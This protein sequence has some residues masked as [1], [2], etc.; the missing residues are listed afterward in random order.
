M[1]EHIKSPA[2][3]MEDLSSPSTAILLVDDNPANLL[4]LRAIFDG[5][6]LKIMEA[7]SGEEALRRLQAEEFAVILLDV[8]MPGLDGFETARQIR[9]GDRCG[10]TPII[11]V[12]AT[13]VDRNQLEAGYSLGAVD[14]L[15]KPVLPVV[16]QA[17]VRGFARLYEANF[18]ARHE[19]DQLRLLIQGT[20]EYAIFMLDPLG[21]IVTWNPGAERLKGYTAAEIIG[22]HFSRFYPQ[23]AIG[24]GWPEYELKAAAEQGRFED[25]GWRIRKDG[26]QFWANVNITAL[27]DE[28][29]ELR[30]FSKITR[31]MTDR[32]RSEESARNLAAEAAARQAAEEN[33][34]VIQEQRERLR[35]TLASIGDAVISTDATGRVTFLN[36]VAERL[37]GWSTDEAAGRDLQEIFQ[38]VNEETRQP[39]ANPALRALREGKII[40]LA[41]HTVL[42]ARNGVEHPIDDSA[43]P[44]RDDQG[45]TIG[46]VLVFRDISERQLNERA[47]Q[48]QVSITETLY[49]I[50]TLLAEER[51]LHRMVQV[52]TDEGTQLSGAQ[53]GAFFYNLQNELGESY[54]L[55]TIS[56][57]PRAEFEKFPMP[58]NTALFGPT[59]EGEGIVCLADVTQD[60]RYG[61]SAPYFGMPAGHLPVRSYL[62][63]PVISR[64]GDVIGGLF[65]GH[66]EVGVFNERHERLLAG[67]AGQAAVA[68]DNARLNLRAQSEAERF[69]LA[70]TAAHLG[71]WSWDIT[72]DVVNMSP[73]A[74]AVFGIPPGPR[75]TWTKMQSLL[76]PDDRE[77]IR[78]EVERIIDQKS[79]YDVEYRVV[80]RDG[81]TVWV[82]VLGRGVYNEAGEV[83]TMYG[84][85]RDI[86][87]LHQTRQE[88][89]SSEERLRLALEAGRMGVWDWN[90]V[91][92]DL[93]WS[94]SLE[95]LYG[96]A[97]G[98]F[99]GTAEDFQ[100]LIHPD[101]RPMVNAAIRRAI[102]ERSGFDL[103]FRNVWPNGDVHWVAGKA[104][105]FT[106]ENGR[107]SRMIGIGIDVTRRKRSE[108][109][110]QFLADASAALSVLVDFDSTLQKV[111]S[112]AVPSFADWASVVV[113]EPDNQLRRVAVA[114]VDPKK[115]DLAHKT[116]RDH[117]PDPTA[118]T[119]VWNIIRTG[120]AE[121]FS[122]VSEEL[123]T[124]SVKNK[125]VL[126]VLRTLGLRSY[127]GVPLR[128]RGK[129][130]GVIT[131]MTAESG[132]RY[133]DTDLAV[134]QDLAN[135]TAIAI[136]NSQLYKEL[137]DA[138]RRKDEFLATLAHELRNPLAPIRNGLE[139]L[140][141]TGS[142][143]Q[144]VIDARSM[145]ERQLSQL[146]RLVDDLLDVSRITRNKLELRKE[147]VDLATIIHS[148][149]ETSRPLIEQ[150]GHTFSLTLPPAPILID[151]DS[152]RLAQVFS[153]LLNNS[154]K[155]TNP[156]GRI[157]LSSELHGDNVT[158]RVKDSGLGIPE[159]ALSTIFEMF[160]QVARHS[161]RAQG[162]LGIGL[163]LVRRI[164]EM[165][166]GNVVARSEGPGLGSEFIVKLPVRR[167]QQAIPELT[168]SHLEPRPSHLKRKILIVDDNRDAAISLSMMLQLMGNETAIAEDGLA[169][170]DMA[171]TFRPEMILL[172]I[173]LPRLN[174][175]DACRRIRTL[176]GAEKIVIVALTGWG[177]DADRQRSHEAG[178]D[179]HLVKPVEISALQKL[180]ASQ[181]PK[182]SEVRS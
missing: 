90:I 99:G 106:G 47:L 152:V 62:A 131:F 123:L 66:A 177:Q 97:P 2:A 46:S 178:F 61:K 117:P 104:K 110:A 149:I 22:Q 58:R 39:V 122:E 100:Q 164:V 109:T 162:G 80:R 57:V 171:A 13:D 103:E 53:F 163:T 165:H 63:V 55:Y 64:N 124:A 91:T 74:A 10:E 83:V 84:V 45:K 166:G 141:L 26:S 125:E 160:S 15:V 28:S 14:F 67:I 38:I 133:D 3:G 111:A 54:T 135:R 139:V 154:A 31:D 21:H 16:L 172:D 34:R 24:R 69:N 59:F 86:S 20:T 19:A 143:S 101:D 93:K 134:A 95:P 114:H 77:R 119:G 169:A 156:G 32:K 181:Q 115:V 159:A 78:Q 102:A 29:G 41:N 52:V 4:A 116:H 35:V 85:L 170:V 18:R 12:T 11:F 7:S 132:H 182:R 148:A 108:Q 113:V 158:I 60:P 43:A 73:R 23:E 27:R 1:A 126:E 168:S 130:L 112:L 144:T 5:S 127:M 33:F 167:N 68:I 30:G 175:Y 121:V 6:G 48:E 153:N 9:A 17:K 75:M 107:P 76:H 51:D 180:L 128:I 82:S 140:R 98:T 147:R 136:E 118:T 44:I 56:G 174:G 155:Y 25:E 92:G 105:V 70:L 37:V 138:D 72:T 137:R 120:Q 157:E 176:P 142:N 40:G 129:T 96:L 145:M 146:V 161:D 65:F 71:D 173:G 49:R 179:L 50:S 150:A 87:E 36:P 8:E 79:Q 42:I 94:D 151:A 89:E 81:R 88:L